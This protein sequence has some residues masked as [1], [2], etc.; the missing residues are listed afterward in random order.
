MAITNV[1]DGVTTAVSLESATAFELIDTT[2]V[3]ADYFKI[4]EVA[5]VHRLGPSG[6]YLPATNKSGSIV[7]SA[8]PNMAVLEPAWYKITKTE[9]SL[10][11]YVGYGS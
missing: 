4:D 6:N 9:T 3:Y 7:L 2:T 8:Y 5:I 10:E 11:A 1:I